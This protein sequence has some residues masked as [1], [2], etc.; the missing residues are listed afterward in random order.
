MRKMIGSIFRW[1]PALGHAEDGT[2]TV[3]A[4]RIVYG[5]GTGEIFSPSSHTVLNTDK[6]ANHNAAVH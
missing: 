3:V 5:P 6:E 4:H 1:R 2:D